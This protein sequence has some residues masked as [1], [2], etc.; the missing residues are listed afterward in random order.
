MTAW[1]LERPAW[2]LH[3]AILGAALMVGLLAGVRPSLA[4]VVAVGLG[5]VVL[6]LVNIT[7]GVCLFAVL[8]FLD[9]VLPSAAGS[10]TF[11]KALGLLLLLSWLMTIANTEEGR[12]R[13]LFLHPGFLFLLPL[14]IAW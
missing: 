9:A 7:F 8:A 1:R 6:A 14:F 13:G 4:I 2:G 3:V 5:F 12:R 11:A 10:F